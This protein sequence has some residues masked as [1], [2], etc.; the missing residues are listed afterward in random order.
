MALPRPSSRCEG[1][2]MHA[3]WTVACTC[4]VMLLLFAAAL[5]D[6]TRPQR[7]ASTAAG[8]SNDASEPAAPR[9]A[10]ELDGLLAWALERFERAGLAEPRITTARV[11]PST[12]LDQRLGWVTKTEDGAV[13]ELGDD[14]RICC[15]GFRGAV[16]FCDEA[17]RCMLH[18]LAHV[19]ID[20][21]VEDD[22]R[23]RFM[24][25]TGARAWDDPALPWHARGVEQAAETLAWGLHCEPWFSLESTSAC[26]RRTV[27]F[28]ILTGRAP[29]IDCGGCVEELGAPVVPAP[30]EGRP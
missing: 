10:D 3:R 17:E 5:A 26:R 27:G 24:S 15:A 7:N 6:G 14:L 23:Q 30:D 2:D 19:W 22:A 9:H 11:G 25:H 21:N 16:V 8:A 29:A 28:A 13:I 20:Q 12:D 4:L 18:E 1:R